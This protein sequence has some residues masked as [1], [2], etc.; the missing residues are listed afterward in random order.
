VSREGNDV[1]GVKLVNTRMLWVGLLSGPAAWAVQLQTAYALASWACDSGTVALTL[2]LVS[3]ACLLAA[4][5]GAGV[6]WRN[7]Q[8]AGG[9][10]SSTDETTTGRTRLMALLGVMTGTLFSLV[11]LAQWVAAMILDPCSR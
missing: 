8:A 7:W 10:P 5:G 11:I 4:A 2:H 3:G 9:W 6:A 1:P